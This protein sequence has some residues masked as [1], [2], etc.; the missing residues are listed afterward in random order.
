MLVLADVAGVGVAE[1]TGDSGPG[2]PAAIVPGPGADGGWS[3]A[4]ATGET[5]GTGG[6][7]GGGE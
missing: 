7:S 5:S 2:W 3:V 6:G 1:A 4:A